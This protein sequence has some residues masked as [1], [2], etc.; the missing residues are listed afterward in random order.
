MK[1]LVSALAVVSVAGSAFGLTQRSLNLSETVDHIRDLGDITAFVTMEAA[2][3]DSHVD[4]RGAPVYSSMVNG[5]F[6]STPN[7]N[8]SWGAAGI[9]GVV[10]VNDYGTTTGGGTPF[11]P[12]TNPLVR[13][14]AMRFIGGVVA[15]G[16]VSFFFV[17]NDSTTALAFTVNLATA[18]N[19]IWTIGLTTLL[20]EVPT[21]GFWVMQTVSGGPNGNIFF[22]PAQPTVGYQSTANDDTFNYGGATGVQPISERFELQVPAPGAAALMGL[23]G[24]VGL[25]RRR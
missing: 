24:L 17:Q 3:I 13:L 7:A 12:G 16:P 6:G 8:L 22:H 9:S 11:T 5:P 19:F 15:P 10:G 4:E 14:D 1:T 20:A 23:A 21:E 25:R 18:G 2:P